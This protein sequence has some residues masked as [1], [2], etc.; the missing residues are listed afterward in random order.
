M[1]YLEFHQENK[2]FH[3]DVFMPACELMITFI[4]CGQQ[5]SAFGRP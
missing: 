5:G 1:N 3:F 4:F 2:I